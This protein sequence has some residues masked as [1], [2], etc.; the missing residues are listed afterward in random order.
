MEHLAGGALVTGYL[1]G[2]PVRQGSM[3]VYDH[4]GSLRGAEAISLR[5]L[6]FSRGMSP[7]SENQ[8]CDEVL[9]VMRGSGVVYLDG[10]AHSVAPDTG[11]YLAPGVAFAVRNDE[12]VPLT[13]ASSRCPDPDSRAKVPDIGQDRSGREDT[14]VVHLSDRRRE[15]TADRWYCVLLDGR[16]GSRRVTQFVGSIPSGRAPDHHHHYEEVLLILKGSGRVWTGE[17]STAI[18]E[19]SCIFLPR[20]QVHCLENTGNDELRLLGVFYPAGSPAVRYE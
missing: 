3:A 8:S 18:E 5:I 12:D 20:K 17:V 4:F 2:N 10:E 19:G 15:T 6:T 9:Y 7:T 11:L 1:E 13:I 14:P 16:V